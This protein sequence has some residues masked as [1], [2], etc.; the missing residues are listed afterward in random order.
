MHWS[1]NLLFTKKSQGTCKLGA[2]DESCPS[3]FLFTLVMWKPCE[4]S[5][6]S[7]AV[8]CVFMVVTADGCA[9]SFPE[10]TALRGGLHVLS[11]DA[12]VIFILLFAATLAGTVSQH[13][14]VS[15]IIIFF[16]GSRNYLYD[17]ETMFVP[18][19]LSLVAWFFRHLSQFPGLKPVEGK[20]LDAP[21]KK[22]DLYMFYLLSTQLT[23]YLPVWL[24]T[25]W[26][27]I[28]LS[29]CLSGDCSAP[30]TIYLAS[31]FS[32]YLT[33][34]LSDRDTFH[35]QKVLRSWG[36]SVL[37]GFQVHMLR[38]WAACTGLASPQMGPHAHFEGACP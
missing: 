36:V 30:L 9:Q 20:P 21:A 22:I 35:F 14:F 5:A 12:V 15:L 28:C 16:S 29:I 31:S 24:S 8:S 13:V 3:S 10:F 37:F 4:S 7:L 1:R 34:H 17:F 23:I 32:V 25:Y 11:W 18:A 19:W 38:A 33:I 2:V 6:A 27:S 26:L